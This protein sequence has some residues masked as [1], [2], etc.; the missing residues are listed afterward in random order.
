MKPYEGEPFI[1][2]PATDRWKIAIQIDNCT[3]VLPLSASNL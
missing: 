3:Q 1:G 2:D